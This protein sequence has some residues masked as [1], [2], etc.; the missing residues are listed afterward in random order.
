MANLSDK[1]R[2]KDFDSFVGSSFSISLL[3]QLTES[4][5]IPN[6]LLF[7]GPKGVGKTTACRI[8][9]RTLNG[10]GG[11]STSYIEIDAASNNGVDEVRELQERVRYHHSGEWRVVV[12]DEAH[13]LTSQ[14]FN[15]LL[16]VL[17]EPPARTVFIMVTTR[18]ES[19]PDTVKSRAMQFRFSAI[20][21]KDIAV[22]LAEITVNESLPISDGN[23]LLRI[24]EVSE[25]SLRSAVNLLQ[26]V[27]Y[28]N[29]PTVDTVNELTGNNVDI[30][31]FMY[32]MMSGSLYEFEA[33]LTSLL[34]KSNDVDRLLHNIIEAL[35][36][37]H[38]NG[39]INNSQ[40]LSC[41]GS[42][43]SMRK[44]RNSPTDLSRGYFEAGMYAM[45]ASNFWNGE[46]GGPASEA[47]RPASKDEISSIMN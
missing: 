27:T 14:A 2:P 39:D 42:V 38:S 3:R 5:N 22:R 1:Y 10:G 20:P 30:K 25:G 21:S 13:S 32:S 29:D 9:N 28:Y 47:S 31:D 6:F 46:E 23:V 11:D 26:Q 33:E 44:I 36:F 16:K 37:F 7:S 12:L 40:F 45:F 4:G 41:M 17:E 35:R 8:L 43:W 19:I 24:A 18:P 15:A 34:Y